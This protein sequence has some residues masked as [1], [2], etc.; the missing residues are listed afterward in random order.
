MHRWNHRATR[1][2]DETDAGGEEVRCASNGTVSAKTTRRKLGQFTH[3]GGAIDPRLLEGD[4]I[5]HNARDTPTTTRSLPSI[6]AER[7]ALVETAKKR[8]QFVMQPRDPALRVYAARNSRH[9]GGD[10]LGLENGGGHCILACM[11]GT[12]GRISWPTLAMCL[13]GARTK[14]SQREYLTE[15]FIYRRFPNGANCS[16][17]TGRYS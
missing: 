2:H 13:R 3:Y 14:R 16:R 6:F 7:P 4:S 5:G 9:G 10:S 17:L 12:S 15:C 11:G 1:V 8:G